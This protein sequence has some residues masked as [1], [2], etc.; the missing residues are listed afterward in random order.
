MRIAAYKKEIQNTL[1]RMIFWISFFHIKMIRYSLF[2]N[3]VAGD[4]EEKEKEWRRGPASQ[5]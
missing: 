3:N 2:S 5:G 4:T 1:T